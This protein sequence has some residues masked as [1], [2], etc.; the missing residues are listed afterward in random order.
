MEY[1]ENKKIYKPNQEFVVSYFL[2]LYDGDDHHV[3]ENV[4]LS[5]YLEDE[6]PRS[7]GEITLLLKQEL[8]DR[9]M[10]RWEREVTIFN[11]WIL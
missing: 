2:R 4:S 3:T 9:A 8:E 10:H 11:W 7:D 6:K 1:Y 5:M